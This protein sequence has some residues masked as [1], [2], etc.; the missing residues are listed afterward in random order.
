[1][2]Y[3]N[4]KA[5]D[6]VK[7]NTHLQKSI[8]RYR[9]NCSLKEHLGKKVY[10]NPYK[11]LYL[12]KAGVFFLCRTYGL[13]LCREYLEDSCD[14]CPVFEKTGEVSCK[15]TPWEEI[16]IHCQKGTFHY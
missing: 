6:I 5:E 13:R 9:E 14:H 12:A 1:M 11:G 2:L 15:T 10:Y 8:K 16:W 7:M 4:A 3:L